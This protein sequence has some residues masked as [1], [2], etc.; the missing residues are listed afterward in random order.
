M[1]KEMLT[2][3]TVTEDLLA[4]RKSRFAVIR[5]VFLLTF[6]PLHLIALFII[7]VFESIVGRILFYVALGI[8][9]WY[10][11]EML[12]YAVYKKSVRDGKYIIET[13]NLTAVEDIVVVESKSRHSVVKR[14]VPHLCFGE[15]KWRADPVGGADREAV[16]RAAEIGDTYFVVSKAVGSPILCAYNGKQY[17][18]EE[19]L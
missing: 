3:E 1:T 11:F 17:A 12:R 5:T 9:L 19:N 18:W 13:D 7:W 14:S 15:R 8:S 10:F 4:I 6:V 2:K 16:C